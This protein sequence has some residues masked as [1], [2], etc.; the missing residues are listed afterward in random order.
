M[1]AFFI[2]TAATIYWATPVRQHAVATV[3][4]AQSHRDGMI[5]AAQFPEGV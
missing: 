5:A 3:T 4:A 1:I 2:I